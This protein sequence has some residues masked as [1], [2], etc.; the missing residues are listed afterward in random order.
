[1]CRDPWDN[2]LLCAALCT[3]AAWAT[4][5]AGVRRGPWWMKPAASVATAATVVTATLSSQCGAADGAWEASS[6]SLLAGLLG[7]ACLP[8]PSALGFLWSPCESLTGTISRDPVSLSRCLLSM[9][10]LELREVIARRRAAPHLRSYVRF[11]L[12]SSEHHERALTA[13]SHRLL[14]LCI[15]AWREVSLLA[16]HGTMTQAN[17]VPTADS[18][19]WSLTHCVEGLAD[20]TEADCA[21]HR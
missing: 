20:M 14:S 19:A 3:C 18:S 10:Y 13:R 17:R 12:S 2:A 21:S 15:L 4:H 11:V 1:M 9:F 8:L 16:L 7:A 6:L 5:S